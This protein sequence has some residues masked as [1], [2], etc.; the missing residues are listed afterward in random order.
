MKYL[1][2]AL[3]TMATTFA[4]ADDNTL[5]LNSGSCSTY[6]IQSAGNEYTCEIVVHGVVEGCEYMAAA[7]P[8]IQVL[9]PAGPH[10]GYL[11]SYTT[12]SVGYQQPAGPDAWARA[13]QATT[14]VRFTSEENALLFVAAFNAANTNLVGAW[15]HVSPSEMVMYEKITL[16]DYQ[17]MPVVSTPNLGITYVSAAYG[18]AWSYDNTWY[19]FIYYSGQLEA[20]GPVG[21]EPRV[22]LSLPNSLM[23]RL[24]SISSTATPNQQLTSE[25]HWLYDFECTAVLIGT[26]EDDMLDILLALNGGAV[27]VYATNGSN[28]HKYVYQNFE[29]Y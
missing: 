3:V 24:V 6:N 27:N 16:T 29:E 18:Y 10:P 13:F 15:T 20:T 19:R 12:S 26:D 9:Q 5:M 28:H 8:S 22:T 1:L 25:T 14:V 4:V 17:N 7:Q 23:P 2:L 11:G 21:T